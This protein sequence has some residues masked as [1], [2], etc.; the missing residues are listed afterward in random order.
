MISKSGEN[1]ESAA[2]FQ[3]TEPISIPA[4]KIQ[5][6]NVSL[7]TH[8]STL[9]VQKR[10]VSSFFFVKRILRPVK[11]VRLVFKFYCL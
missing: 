3:L 1:G 8:Q 6:F 5:H 4:I 9:R 10:V 7:L 11:D 2:F